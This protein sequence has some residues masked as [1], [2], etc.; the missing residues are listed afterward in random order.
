MSN[1]DW[2]LTLTGAL[3]RSS[4]RECLPLAKKGPRLFEQ[5][6]PHTKGL[7]ERPHQGLQNRTPEAVY[8]SASGGGAMIVDKHG[9][10]EG[11]PIPLH[12][13]GTAFEEVELKNSGI[14]EDENRSSAVQLRVEPSA[15]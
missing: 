3:Q 7:V 4:L 5:R 1:P 10:A 14:Q 6:F 9:A 15:T 8:Q 2:A 13:T 11:I 12:S